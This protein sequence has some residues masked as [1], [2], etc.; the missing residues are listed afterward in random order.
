MV[1]NYIAMQSLSVFCFE[2][3]CKTIYGKYKYLI[4]NRKSGSRV[5]CGFVKDIE[6]II[7]QE[8]VT[9]HFCSCCVR[10][11]PELHVIPCINRWSVE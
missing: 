10:M 9:E 5:K 1:L 6:M 2:T 8:K 4:K 3:K 7:C 11:F